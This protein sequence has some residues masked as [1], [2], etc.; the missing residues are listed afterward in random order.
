MSGGTLSFGLEDTFIVVG[1]RI[2]P[3]GKKKAAGKAAEG[4]LDLVLGF[5]QSRRP[6]PGAEVLDINMGMSGIDEK[7]DDAAG[8]YRD[9]RRDFSALSIDSSHVDSTGGGAAAISGPGADQFYFHGIRKIRK[10]A[11]HC[12]KIRRYVYSA[13]SFG[14]GTSQ[15]PEEKDTDYPSDYRACLCLGH[16]KRRYHCGR[17]S[18]YGGANPGAALEA[19]E[20]IRYC[21]ANGLATTILRSVQY[22]VWTAGAELC[23]IRLF[24]GQWPYRGRT[25]DGHGSQSVA[26]AAA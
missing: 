22:F 19:L 8:H 25:D 9:G 18:D 26:G 7:R 23:R 14:C 12:E 17:A 5:A 20:T 24:S 3:T 13:S 16:G 21:R 1:E 2:N 10:T 11:A 6:A 4:D 15:E